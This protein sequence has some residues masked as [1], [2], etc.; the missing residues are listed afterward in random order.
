MPAARADREI[1][2]NDGVLFEKVLGRSASR[3][4]PRVWK[5]AKPRLGIRIAM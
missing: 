1:V 3:N 4:S 2:P 5:R